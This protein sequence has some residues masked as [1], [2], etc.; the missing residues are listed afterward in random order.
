MIVAFPRS[1]EN[2][3]HQGSPVLGVQT[4]RVPPLSPFSR[5]TVCDHPGPSTFGPH[6][7]SK[8]K[9]SGKVF[10]SI[11]GCVID[12]IL[13]LAYKMMLVLR[14]D[15]QGSARTSIEIPGLS[16]ATVLP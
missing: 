12:P 8:S 4:L 6:K 10:S 7:C 5:T 1:A 13:H 14:V 9:G 16:L 2:R 15:R 11:S 3:F